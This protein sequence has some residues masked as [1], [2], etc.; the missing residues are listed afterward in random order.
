[1]PI[2]SNKLSPLDSYRYVIRHRCEPM[3]NLVAGNSFQ[4]DY[5]PTF[6]TA[7]LFLVMI[8]FVGC[9]LYTMCTYDSDSVIQCSTV[10]GIVL[11]APAK[12]RSAIFEST[13][14]YKNHQ[15]VMSM[16][17]AI[18]ATD[19]PRLKA[20]A[21]QFARFYRRATPVLMA[22]VWLAALAMIVNPVVIYVLLGVEYSPVIPS[23]IPFVNE[24]QMRGYL[25]NTC[26]HIVCVV[27]AACG[28]IVADWYFASII[29]HVYLSVSLV[30][31]A[32]DTL[33]RYID[34]NRCE[35]VVRRQHCKL[36]Q[37]HQDFC[38]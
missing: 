24:K 15:N 3:A 27:M 34:E 7:I 22:L 18:D 30:D 37:L 38:A 12:F 20:K 19:S 10:T 4:P 25:I 26:Y 1:M 28:N 21:E 33:N 29:M 23:Y 16:Y 5:R 35:R 31:D 13:R 14:W 11:Q 2:K 8:T 6:G 32:K 36:Y 9:C 17:S